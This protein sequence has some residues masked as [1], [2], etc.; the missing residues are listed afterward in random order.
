MLKRIALLVALLVLTCGCTTTRQTVTARAATEQLLLSRAVDRAI[1][2]LNFSL[3]HSKKVYLDTGRFTSVDQEYYVSALENALARSGGII[4]STPEEADMVV[5]PRVGA[6][7][8]DESMALIGLPEIPLI[9]PGAGGVT[10]PELPLFKNKTQTGTT[11]LRV[12][13]LDS[14]TGAHLQT[15]HAFG[16]AFYSKYVI[17]FIDFQNTD[18]PELEWRHPHTASPRP[19]RNR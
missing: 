14:K 1:D 5:R 7:G 19:I 10:T 8:T 4:L 13:V 18:V 11:K 2:Q 17:F 12:Y 15:Q 16:K 6:L 3:V 9:I